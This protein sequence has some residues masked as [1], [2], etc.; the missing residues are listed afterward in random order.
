MT[1]CN[2]CPGEPGIQPEQYGCCQALDNLQF[3][4]RLRLLKRVR[5][6]FSVHVRD[7]LISIF[8]LL[9]AYL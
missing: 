9:V 1:R 6:S 3:A 7:L 5:S 2:L 4:V 8:R